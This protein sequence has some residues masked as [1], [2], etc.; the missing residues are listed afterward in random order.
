M[1]LYATLTSERATKAQGGNNFID[2]K[3][4]V[5][6]ASDSKHIA[7]VRLTREESM[8]G[9]GLTLRIH[10]GTNDTAGRSIFFA[11]EQLKGN[12]QKGE[13]EHIKENGRY[14]TGKCPI[15]S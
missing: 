2:I 8:K 6:S 3:L 5:G 11:D 4:N 14:F 10:E 9:Y 12:K 7:T 13:C 15:C 1:K